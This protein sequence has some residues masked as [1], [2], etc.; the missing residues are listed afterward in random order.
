[1]RY[2]IIAV[3][4]IQDSESG[5]WISVSPLRIELTLLIGKSMTK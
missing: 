2:F 4:I 5:S 1:M 3:F